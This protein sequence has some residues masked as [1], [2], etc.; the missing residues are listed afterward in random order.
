M[1]ENIHTKELF[2]K[3]YSNRDWQF[4][5][6]ILADCVAKGSPGKILDLGA[7]LGYFVE[8]CKRFGIECIGLEG[9]EYAVTEAKKR[10]DID[11]RLHYLDEK[12][13]FEDNSF[14]II[15][16][17]QVVEHLSINTVKLMLKESYRVLENEGI[18]IVNSPCKY[19]RKEQAEKTH[20]NLY[21]PK[22]L[23]KEL[24]YVGFKEI[25]SYNSPQYLLGN[26]KFGTS[27]MRGLFMV[28]KFDF[29]SATANCVG[30]KRLDY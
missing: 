5:K 27:A 6:P 14:S 3:Y 10:F 21:T 30:K 7:G 1:S 12:L 26:S 11:I 16:C 18:I 17:N 13:P 4:Y 28:F 2:D 15:L 23:I 9:S 20:I 25:K 29:L 19:N 22:S 24:E 8:C